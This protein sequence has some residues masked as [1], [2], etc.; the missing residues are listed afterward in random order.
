MTTYDEPELP[1]GVYKFEAD[2]TPRDVQ[3]IKRMVAE[4]RVPDVERLSEAMRR[5]GVLGGQYAAEVARE[6]AALDA[7]REDEA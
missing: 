3:T 7:A 6:Y 1:T 2:L 5:A 4:A